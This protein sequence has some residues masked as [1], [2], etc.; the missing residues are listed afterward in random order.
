MEV[1]VFEGLAFNWAVGP[2]SHHRP[3]IVEGGK[4]GLS[5]GLDPPPPFEFDDVEQGGH[6][7][8]TAASGCQ[9]FPEMHRQ[10]KCGE[11]PLNIDVAKT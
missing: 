5:P 7:L 3:A 10:V 4:P 9:R 2:N 6:I 11:T 1:I 8:E